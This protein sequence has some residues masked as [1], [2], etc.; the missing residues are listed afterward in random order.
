MIEDGRQSI[1]HGS[2]GL[3]HHRQDK[4]KRDEMGERV[5]QANREVGNKQEDKRHEHH[6][7][8]FSNQ[9]CRRVNPNIVHSRVA[10][11][12]IHRLLSLEYNY[13]GLKIKEHLH[14]GHEVDSTSHVLHALLGTVVV[15]L[16]E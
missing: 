6:D 7:W 14:D 10:L 5:S 2:C 15:T 16:P 13:S 3:D 4:V 1:A 9:L 11:T 12:H 8:D